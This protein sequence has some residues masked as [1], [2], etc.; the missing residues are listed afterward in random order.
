M[1]W[2]SRAHVTNDGC[3]IAHCFLPVFSNSWLMNNAWASLGK[4]RTN[5]IHVPNVSRDDACTALNI[6][7]HCAAALVGTV[8]VSGELRMASRVGSWSA[9]VMYACKSRDAE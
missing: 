6:K 4:R 3:T 8:A 9:S 2:F 1:Y 7:I 5:L